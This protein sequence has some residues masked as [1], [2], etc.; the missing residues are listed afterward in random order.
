MPFIKSPSGLDW[1][2][3]VGSQG[4]LRWVSND[5]PIPLSCWTDGD[6]QMPP[7]PASQKTAVEAHTDAVIAGYR[8]S[9]KNYVHSAEELAEMRATFGEGATIV[10]VITG[11]K[12]KV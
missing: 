5:A 10:D 9:R 6:L 12:V 2:Y 3:K 7:Q 11:Q 1:E 8:E 4:E